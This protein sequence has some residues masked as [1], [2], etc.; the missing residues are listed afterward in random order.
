[1]LGLDLPANVTARLDAG[2]PVL[3]LTRTQKPK[4]S[5][6]LRVGEQVVIGHKRT[7]VAGWLPP[8]FWFLSPAIQAFEIVPRS[9]PVEGMAIVRCRP[10]VTAQQLETEIEKVAVERGT[11]FAQT[12]PH[13]VM[14]AAATAD[15]L[16]LFASALFTASILVFLACGW[17]SMPFENL[18]KLLSGNRRRASLFFTVKTLLGL[19]VVF[20]LGMEVFVGAAQEALSDTIGGP[21]LIWVYVVGCAGVLYTSINDQR[22]RCRVCQRLLGFPIYIGCRGSLFLDWAGTEFLCPHGHG[23]LY[24]PHHVPCWEEADR[25]VLLEA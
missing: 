8:S 16:W 14:L 6:T 5:D 7:L 9:V 23:A 20:V 3:L 12:A 15:P 11:E 25:W 13:A 2:E 1:M 4:A 18:R 22:S 17:R 21:T 19:A 10:G 24:V